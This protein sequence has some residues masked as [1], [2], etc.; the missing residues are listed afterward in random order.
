MK[1]HIQKVFSHVRA[2]LEELRARLMKGDLSSGQNSLLA[3]S[4]G[5]LAVHE[6]VRGLRNDRSAFER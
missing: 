6:A 5:D 3:K 1:A 4:I 2:S